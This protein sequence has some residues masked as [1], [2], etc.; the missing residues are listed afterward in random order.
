MDNKKI[1][2]W[3]GRTEMEAL[4]VEFA[5][6]IFFCSSVCK[7]SATKKHRGTLVL[8]GDAIKRHW[9]QMKKETI[10][11]VKSEFLTE[12]LSREKL[13]PEEVVQFYNCLSTVQHNRLGI[14]GISYLA[15]IVFNEPQRLLDEIEN[16]K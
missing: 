12:L 4:M 9:K 16:L 3:C 10:Q 1:C 2:A 15:M 13:T 5:S 7:V 14:L 6:G 8:D 11:K